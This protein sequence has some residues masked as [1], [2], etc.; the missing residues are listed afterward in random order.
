M[1]SLR[2][3]LKLSMAEVKPEGKISKKKEIISEEGDNATVVM[4][5]MSIIF[6]SVLLV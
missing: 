6:C 5:G 1:T 3:A 4:L 2:V